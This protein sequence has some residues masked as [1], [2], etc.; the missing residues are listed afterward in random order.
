MKTRTRGSSRIGR[1]FADGRRIDEALRRAARKA[2]R[3]HERH[4][5]PVVLWRDGR[6]ALV[7]AR[8]LRDGRR[9][10][11]P[12]ASQAEPGIAQSRKRGGGGSQRPA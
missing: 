4:D 8:E 5:V 3:T 7:P 1:I 12:A 11:R 6:V 9:P 2:I 10:A